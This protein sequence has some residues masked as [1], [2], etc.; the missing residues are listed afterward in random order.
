MRQ[1]NRGLAKATSVQVGSIMI[2]EE[3]GNMK[4]STTHTPSNAIV[5]E[6]A[7]FDDLMVALDAALQH[8]EIGGG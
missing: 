7:D 5:V 3:A 2:T 8:L 6:R 4:I 1:H